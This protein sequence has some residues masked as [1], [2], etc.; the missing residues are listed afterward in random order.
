ML[1][2]EFGG[3]VPGGFRRCRIL[4]RLGLLCAVSVSVFVVERKEPFWFSVPGRLGCWS[5]GVGC[6]ELGSVG[7]TVSLIRVLET[8]VMPALLLLIGRACI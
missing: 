6:L 7:L 3:F 5:V 4:V 1:L 2:L 8:L